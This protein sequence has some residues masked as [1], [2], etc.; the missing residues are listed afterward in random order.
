MLRS[1]LSFYD[2]PPEVLISDND[3]TYSKWPEP[4]L[5]DF[6]EI[7]LIKTLT[8]SPLCNIYAERMIRTFREELTDQLIFYG[9]RDLSKCLREYVEYY[10]AER[11]NSSLKFSAPKCEFVAESKKLLGKVRRKKIL[12]GLIT[13]YSYA[14]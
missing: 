3:A 2:S 10:N 9:E 11:P 5:K 7:N 8:K 12:D 6:Y 1:F 14:G 4:F 13:S